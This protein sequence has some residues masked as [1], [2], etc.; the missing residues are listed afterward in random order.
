VLEIA[1][2]NGLMDFAMPF[3]V[4]TMREMT[5][6]ID[7]LVQKEK[8]KEEAIAEE[9]KKA[10]EALASGYNGM[11]YGGGDPNSMVVYG[12]GMGGGMGMQQQ[13]YGYGY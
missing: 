13:G 10:E 4:Q 2:R 9:K 8:K 12:A 11:E 1:W 5:S 6:N 7:A 3:M